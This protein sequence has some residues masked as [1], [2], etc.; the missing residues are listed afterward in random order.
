[1]NDPLIPDLQLVRFSTSALVLSILLPLETK[2]FEEILQTFIL[3]AFLADL[4]SPHH[5]SSTTS[6]LMVSTSLNHTSSQP[7]LIGKGMSRNF[8]STQMQVSQS[9]EAANFYQG[10]PT[11]DPITSSQL[12]TSSKNNSSAILSSSRAKLESGFKS[13]NMG[14]L[15]GSLKNGLGYW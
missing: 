8:R 5:S 13:S 7:I 11:H 2:R 12:L 1:M 3:K 6:N 4:L 14:Q 10:F 9:R 15:E